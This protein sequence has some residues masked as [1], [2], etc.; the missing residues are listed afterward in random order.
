VQGRIGSVAFVP[1]RVSVSTVNHPGLNGVTYDAYD[2][3]FQMRDK[4][5]GKAGE[6]MYFDITTIVPQGQTHDGRTFRMLPTKDVPRQPM[7]G[8]G[9]P[10]VQGWDIQYDPD[11]IPA[12]FVSSLGSLRIEYGTRKG[13][14]LPGRIYFCTPAV[15]GSFLAGNFEADI[16]E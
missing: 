15:K 8:P 10:E 12:S 14:T 5:H 4:I 2:L 11:K 13:T 6:D 16:G 3:H 9:A 7:A 1:E